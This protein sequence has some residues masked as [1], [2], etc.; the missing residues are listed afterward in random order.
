MLPKDTRSLYLVARLPQVRPLSRAPFCHNKKFVQLRSIYLWP[1]GARE[2]GFVKELVRTSKFS[3]RSE[4]VTTPRI[5]FVIR[6]GQ[7]QTAGKGILSTQR[8]P[9]LGF[10]KIRAK[11]LGIK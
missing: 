10:K 8:Q 3:C 1:K 7:N 5:R 9:R 4:T 6:L 11:E 2:R